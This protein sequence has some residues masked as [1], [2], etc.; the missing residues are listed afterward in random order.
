MTHVG[1]ER[2]TVRRPEALDDM[3][4]END[5]A[6]PVL[7]MALG[8]KRRPIVPNGPERERIR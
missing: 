6:L 3:M 8:L 5:D 4:C 1:A 2:I 7:T